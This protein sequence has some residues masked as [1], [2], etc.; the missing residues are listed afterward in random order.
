MDTDISGVQ[1]EIGA[2]MLG[3]AAAVVV[4]DGAGLE[5]FRAMRVAAD[6]GAAVA[7]S[8]ESEGAFADFVGAA[9]EYF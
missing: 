3:P 6:Y 7:F 9:D 8:G 2:G 5:G 1:G 4:V